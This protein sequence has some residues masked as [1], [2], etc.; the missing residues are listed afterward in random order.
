MRWTRQRRRVTVLQGGFSV[1]EQPARRRTALMRTAKPCGSGTRCWCQ[2]VG[3]GCDS[4]GSF[5]PEAGGDGD[6]KE[7]V[8]EE[9]TA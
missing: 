1:S 3:G 5:Q 7:F 6:K 8:A 2:A 9:I 4:T